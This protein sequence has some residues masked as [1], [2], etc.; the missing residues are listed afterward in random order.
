[1]LW[2]ELITFAIQT[3]VAGTDADNN[4]IIKQRLEAA[5]MTD[6]AL[7]ALST[8][9][10]GNPEL[11]ARLEQQF[12]VSLSSGVGAIPAGMMV[13]YLREGVV[14]DSDGGGNNGLGNVLAR[15][16]RYAN[17]IRDQSTAQGLYCVADNQIYARP[18]GSSFPADTQ[19]PLVIDAPFTPTT[20][21]LDTTVPDEVADNLV[22]LLAVKLR[23]IIAD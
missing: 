2:R 1:M 15:V 14:R 19:G 13:E 12:S 16:N 17:F 10:A 7:H 5:G 20:A 3:A 22:E 21:N 23:G 11:R 8:I 6:Q 18:P 9:V 4:P